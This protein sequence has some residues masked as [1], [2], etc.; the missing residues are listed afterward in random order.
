MDVAVDK[1][2]DDNAAA[3]DDAGVMIPMCR[4]C[5]AGDTKMYGAVQICFVL[6][7]HVCMT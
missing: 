7:R 2:A 1:A 6:I 5:F 3:D 4:S